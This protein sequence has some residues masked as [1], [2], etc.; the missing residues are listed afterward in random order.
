MGDG[1]QSSQ[2]SQC[3]WGGRRARTNGGWRCVSGRPCLA[4]RSPAASSSCCGCRCPL[5][6]VEN[7]CGS[8]QL[9]AHCSHRDHDPAFHTSVT[10]QLDGSVVFRDKALQTIHSQPGSKQ[11]SFHKKKTN[12]QKNVISSRHSHE[13]EGER[14]TK[15]RGG[16]ARPIRP[17]GG[18]VGKCAR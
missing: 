2:S 13:R 10:G 4:R 7:G 5:L 3:M 9:N 15:K 11:W 6:P 14:E 18:R 8:S 1:R 12:K 17:K 16:G